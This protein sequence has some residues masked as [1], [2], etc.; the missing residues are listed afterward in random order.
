VVR[1]LRINVVRSD[2]PIRTTT[3][4]GIGIE[5][6]TTTEAGTPETNS[7]VPTRAG[8]PEMISGVTTP[9]TKKTGM[10]IKARISTVKE[11]IV[12][13]AEKDLKGSLRA[14]KDAIT[15]ATVGTAE[16]AL[17]TAISST[18]TR[19]ITSTETSGGTSA[20]KAGH[21]PDQGVNPLAAVRAISRAETTEITRTRTIVSG[22]KTEIGTDSQTVIP[23]TKGETEATEGLRDLTIIRGIDLAETTTARETHEIFKILI[24]PRVSTTEIRVSTIAKTQGIGIPE[25]AVEI[26]TTT[27]LGEI[28]RGTLKVRLEEADHLRDHQETVTRQEDH[29]EEDHREG[30]HQEARLGDHQVA[31][32]QGIPTSPRTTKKAISGHEDLLREVF[33][34]LTRGT[35]LL[36]TPEL[37]RSGELRKV[38]F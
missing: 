10:A 13:T 29:P 33:L 28:H 14:T 21:H 9:E 37:G 22:I 19:E 32:I 23:R 5:K 36:S 38:E 11:A 18:G 3:R 31:E 15:R 27:I 26:R 30:D 34:L 24:K 8:M 35:N 25:G 17:G 20:I 4:E 2:T 6:T 1:T 12:V 16:E 7:G